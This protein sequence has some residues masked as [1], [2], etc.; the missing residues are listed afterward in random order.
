M[1]KEKVSYVREINERPTNVSYQ[2]KTVVILFCW[3][4]FQIK[5]KHKSTTMLFLNYFTWLNCWNLE[6]KIAV[7]FACYP[8]WQ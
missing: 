6:N 2:N 7:A 5:K 1:E 8:Y 4:Y 3:Y